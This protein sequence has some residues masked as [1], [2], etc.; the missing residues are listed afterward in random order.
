[1]KTILE[2]NEINLE[3]DS[4]SCEIP[5]KR[6]ER[7]QI[8]GYIRPLQKENR[9][10]VVIV[11]DMGDID[12]DEEILKLHGLVKSKIG[13]Y[14]Y[15]PVDKPF[16]IWTANIFIPPK[17]DSLKVQIFKWKNRGEIMINAEPTISK[18]YAYSNLVWKLEKC[19]E[20]VAV[21]EK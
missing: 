7:V 10:A 1:M 4:Y 17:V 16:Q 14:K 19:K 18:D 8:S 15:L 11:F 12:I 13:I 20:S 5:V 9:D 2:V 6:Y 21:K 3:H